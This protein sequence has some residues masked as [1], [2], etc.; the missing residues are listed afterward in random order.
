MKQNVTVVYHTKNGGIDLFYVGNIDSEKLQ[1]AFDL[2]KNMHA[3]K[4]ITIE[5]DA[6]FVSDR[7]YR[8]IF[9]EHQ[10]LIFMK[11]WNINF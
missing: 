3:I 7:E 11:K 8:T 1:L 10:I 9:T 5:H 2:A 6:L 4:C